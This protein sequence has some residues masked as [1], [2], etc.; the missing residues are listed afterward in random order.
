MQALSKYFEYQNLESGKHQKRK[1]G[2]LVIST[3]DCCPM[4]T[5]LNLVSPEPT[6]DCCLQVGCPIWDG[7]WTYAV[8]ATEKENRKRT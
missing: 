2:G 5:G 7:S 6:A 8:L 3:P 4:V 1:Y